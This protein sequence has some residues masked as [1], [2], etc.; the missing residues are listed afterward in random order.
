MA[1]VMRSRFYPLFALGLALVV[2]VGFAR[3]LYLR[4][5]FD[6]PPLTVLMYLHGIV[7]SMWVA[8][9]VIQTRLIAAHQYQAHMRLG[10]AGL[11]VASLVV[12]VGL[13]TV[14]MSASAPR[15]RGLGMT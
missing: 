14:F 13:A 1:A 11:V 3:T 5:W 4:Q 9:Y 8:L 6:V 12:I 15:T 2:L 7:F 10:I